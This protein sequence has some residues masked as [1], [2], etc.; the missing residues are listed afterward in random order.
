MTSG[1]RIAVGLLL[2]LI[3]AMAPSQAAWAQTPAVATVAPTESL[4]PQGG[5]DLWGD[6]ASVPG[7]LL[8]LSWKLGLVVLLAYASMWV[9]RHGL[10][11]RRAAAVGRLS[12]LETANLGGQRTLH[13]VRA[14]SR[15]FLIGATPQ[16]VTALADLGDTGEPG[17]LGDLGADSAC[18]EAMPSRWTR[19][20]T[21][22]RGGNGR[23]PVPTTE[24]GG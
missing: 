2:V 5:G 23:H 21:A 7:L 6:A 18:L 13:L 8:S 15:T 1:R 14:G 24:S 11:V 16:Q 9:M 3:V 20:A 12:V 4:Q 17:C 19:T 10:R 22:Q